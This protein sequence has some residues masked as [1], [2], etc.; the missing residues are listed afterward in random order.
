MSQQTPINP[1]PIPT[2]LQTVRDNWGWFVALGVGLLLLGIVALGR[3][4]AV[5]LA[6]GVFI[7]V[8]LLIAGVMEILHAFMAR[9][10][11]GFF[12]QLLVGVL[13]L[14]AGGS[15]IAHPIGT[16]FFLTLLIGF[17]ILL[18]GIVRIVLAL[19]HR[20]V[21]S[22]LLLLVSGIFAALLG[23][24]IVTRVPFSIGI[25]GLFIALELIFNGISLLMLG[26]A[27]KNIPTESEQSPKPSPSE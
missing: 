22:W 1:M 9:Q 21:G 11:R 7:A 25:I 26:I 23:I 13:Y 18:H 4:V 8:L 19:Q 15:L 24:L 27:A 17:S 10:W 3:C 14:I 6:A 16:V 2:D 20:D 5:S 12:L